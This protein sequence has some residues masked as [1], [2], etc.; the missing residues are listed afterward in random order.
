MKLHKDDVQLF[1]LAALQTFDLNGLEIN[2]KLASRELSSELESDFAD[3]NSETTLE[4]R[5]KYFNISNAKPLD[6]QE[7]ILKLDDDKKV[8]Y[9]IRHMGENRELPFIQFYP[10]FTIKNKSEA[11]EIYEKLKSEFKVFKPL[12]VCF[13]ANRTNDADFFGSSYM[14][15]TTKRIKE[16]KTWEQEK[17]LELRKIIDDSYYEWYKK[18]YEK[19]HLD[20]PELA[21]KVTLNSLDS[22]KDSL[23]QGLLHYVLYKGEKIGLIAGERSPLLGHEGIYFH[24]IYIDKKWKGKGLAKAIQ[25][26][27]VTKLAHENDYIW[28]TIDSSNLPSYKTAIANGRRPVRVECF[29]NL[30]RGE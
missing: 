28:G 14:V 7:K 30:E 13:W 24:E 22:M 25:R 26:K 18:G 16:L 4:A 12:W 2:D 27:F 5:W 19:F 29:V 21:K 11:F 1:A 6:Y 20:V 15:S 3:L 17:E 23:E 10:N 9:G 8:I